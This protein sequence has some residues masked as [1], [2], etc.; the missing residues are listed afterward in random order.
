MTQD[1]VP[2]S[3]ELPFSRGEAGTNN[4]AIHWTVIWG[5]GK[6]HEEQESRVRHRDGQG[7]LSAGSQR[8]PLGRWHLTDTCRAG[9]GK[10]CVKFWREECVLVEGSMGKRAGSRT[11]SWSRSRAGKGRGWEVGS[12]PSQGP[13]GH[14][15][16]FHFYSICDRKPLAAETGNPT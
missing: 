13:W 5:G 11:I 14:S 8:R 7:T 9:P 10:D 15:E 6:R 1:K 2:G 12:T 16:E 3:R 4:K